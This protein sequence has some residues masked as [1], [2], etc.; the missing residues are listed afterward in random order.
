LSSVARLMSTTAGC[1]ATAAIPRIIWVGVNLCA[2]L[3][4]AQYATDV[5]TKSST[6][7]VCG[8]CRH[9]K[10]GQGLQEEFFD[11]FEL[12]FHKKAVEGKGKKMG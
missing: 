5:S 4:A 12:R 2:R 3:C 8:T 10:Y 1:C 9:S 7:S 6:C 11:L